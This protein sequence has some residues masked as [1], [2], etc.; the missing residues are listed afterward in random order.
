M[1]EFG[2]HEPSGMFTPTRRLPIQSRKVVVHG[3]VVNDGTKAG[4]QVV[5]F[6]RPLMEKIKKWGFEDPVRDRGAE[7]GYPARWTEV[8]GS[9]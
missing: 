1:S 6:H 5:L 3:R 8:S 2:E 9:K 4:S 7:I